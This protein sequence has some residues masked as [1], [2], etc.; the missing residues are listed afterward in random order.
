VDQFPDP[1]PPV[2][3]SLNFFLLGC[4]KE[5]VYQ[6]LCGWQCNFHARIIKEI[7]RVAKEMLTC[8]WADWTDLM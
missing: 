7:R 4:V 8:P 2:I 6:K 3:M 5:Y 1:T